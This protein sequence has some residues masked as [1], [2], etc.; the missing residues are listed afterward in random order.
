MRAPFQAITEP[1][2]GAD[3]GG[4]GEGRILRAFEG[5]GMVQDGVLAVVF[6]MAQGED[7]E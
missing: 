7:V 3:E 4:N 5:L 1:R 2:S 6:E